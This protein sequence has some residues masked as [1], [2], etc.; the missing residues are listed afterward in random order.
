MS[1]EDV[2]QEILDPMQRLY[3]PPRGFD[4]ALLKNVLSEYVAALEHFTGPDLK[5][6]WQRVR[7]A[8]TARSWPVPGTFVAAAA[9]ARMDREAIAGTDQRSKAAKPA[10]YWHVWERVRNLPLAH[11]AA[12][13][14]VA[15]S[16]KCAILNGAAVANISIERLLQEHQS[17]ERVAARIADNKPLFASDG[18]NLGVMTG[19]NRQ[20]ALDMHRQLLL[21]EA[22]TAQ[23]IGFTGQASRV[24]TDSLVF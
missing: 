2:Q 16:L 3:L 10:T 24:D 9:R 11:E 22:Q 15:W 19:S 14:G 1:R 21:Q 6:A 18:R 8:A 7:D 20:M 5:V 4:D 17:A 23:E 12:E 13:K